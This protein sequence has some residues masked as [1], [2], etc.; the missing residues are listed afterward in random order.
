M[1]WFARGRKSI[2][3]LS[4]SSRFFANLQSVNQIWNLVS[5]ARRNL[6][7]NSSSRRSFAL[8]IDLWWFIM[9]GRALKDWTPTPSSPKRIME[10]TVNIKSCSCSSWKF[11]EDGLPVC[12][13]LWFLRLTS[14]DLGLGSAGGLGGGSFARRLGSVRLW[15]K[16]KGSDCLGCRC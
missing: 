12:L 5:T 9:L 16:R 13:K 8:K 1:T 3:K 7:G 2:I 10:A 14:L 4:T 6:A 11:M 15:Q